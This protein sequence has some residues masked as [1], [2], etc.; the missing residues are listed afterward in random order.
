MLANQNVGRSI[1]IGDV[2]TLR[3][4]GEGNVQRGLRPAVVFQ[5][6]I[7]NMYSPNVIV[8][9]MTGKI[10]KT[11]QPT[12]VIVYAADSGLHKDSMVL[13]ENPESVPKYKLEKY[14][15]TLSDEYMEKIAEAH[16]LATSGIAFIRPDALISL[17]LKARELN[18]A[19]GCPT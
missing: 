12:H 10:K 5:N 15:T 14:I 16:L 19:K 6:N 13:C 8:L 2:Y 4:D 18:L 1:N 17:W 3:F 11:S 7:G 9:P